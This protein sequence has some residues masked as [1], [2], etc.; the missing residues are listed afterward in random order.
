M[1]ARI[2]AFIDLVK[3]LV[4]IESTLLA[5]PPALQNFWREIAPHPV[6]KKSFAEFLERDCATHFSP[7]SIRLIVNTH[8]YQLIPAHTNPSAAN[9]V[10]SPSV[11]KCHHFRIF[12]FIS[13]FFLFDV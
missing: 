3:G 1:H 9:S 7:K 12:S 13:G 4:G 11:L 8:S 6:K 5:T 2:Q 10:E